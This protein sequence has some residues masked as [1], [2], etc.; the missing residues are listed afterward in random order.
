MKKFK[1]P[2]I[3]NI[4]K[5][6]KKSGKKIHCKIGHAKNFYEKLKAIKNPL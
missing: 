3:Q 6:L 5:K 1:L 2:R 4:K